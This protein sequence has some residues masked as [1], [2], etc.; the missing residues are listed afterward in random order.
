VAAARHVV[1]ICGATEIDGHAFSTGLDHSG[2]SDP[3]LDYL[4]D[5]LSESD[6]HSELPGPSAPNP[7][8]VLVGHAFPSGSRHYEN[9][10]HERPLFGQALTATALVRRAIFRPD[11]KSSS[12]KRM[13]L[14]ISTL[15]ELMS[16]YNTHQASQRHDKVYALLGMAS[17]D[18]A[19]AGLSPDYNV[20][21][22][23]LQ[24][25]LFSF[26]LGAHVSIKT[27]PEEEQVEI[28]GKG[29]V[30]GR[31]RA[32]TKGSNGGQNIDIWFSKWGYPKHE[33][34]DLQLSLPA[35]ANNVRKGDIIY[36]LE[37]APRSMIIR[38]SGAVFYVI[39]LAASDQIQSEI[40][41]RQITLIWCWGKLPIISQ[42]DSASSP[43]D[44]KSYWNVVLA[45][46]DTENG[47]GAGTAITCLIAMLSATEIKG[48]TGALAETEAGHFAFGMQEITQPEVLDLVHR[49]DSDTIKQ[50][51]P[52][53][54]QE[55]RDTEKFLVEIVE[56]HDNE[57]LAQVLLEERGGKTVITEAVLAA[58]L[59]STRCQQEKMLMLLNNSSDKT[60]VTET[61]FITA[62][63][64]NLC[65]ERTMRLLLD[66]NNSNALITEAALVAA[67]KSW[68]HTFPILLNYRNDMA[69]ITHAVLVAAAG[70]RWDAPQNMKAI[71]EL[72]RDTKLQATE[73]VICAAAGNPYTGLLVLRILC[74]KLGEEE[75]EFPDGVTQ[76][77]LQ[78]AARN[79]GYD[80]VEIMELLLDLIE[81]EIHVTAPVIEAA[82]RNRWQS[83]SLVRLLCDRSDEALQICLSMGAELETIEW[84]TG[85]LEN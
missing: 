43:T 44:A 8:S 15:G 32:V 7:V 30:L 12:S 37:G 46:T 79:S 63:G 5:T 61:L 33:D 29:C 14:N 55:I 83:H 28:K 35:T 65:R 47:E 26:L 77:V 57:V 25:R 56:S 34:Q 39:A 3:R 68:N 64:T 6:S 69:E 84:L 49:L 1:I 78:A 20:P 54:P 59:K 13:T 42:S 9:S 53:I 52:W 18:I 73:S 16:M 75:V 81:G 4:P 10:A 85:T 48:H 23:E 40:F 24:R 31:V 76:S 36:L 27:W 66:N 51:L 62:A 2:L 71:L 74:A 50:L 45:L 80:G 19:D 22:E 58:A 11:F 17:D 38:R 72:E 60:V 70:N 21:W 41:P 82:R 67:A